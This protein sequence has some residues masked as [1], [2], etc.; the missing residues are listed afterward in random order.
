MN[1]FGKHEEKDCW[2]RGLIPGPFT[3]ET[4]A[5]TARPR[6][7]CVK[8]NCFKYKCALACLVDD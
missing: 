2:L 8:G 7:L 4:D 6:E 3:Q 1:K 5:L